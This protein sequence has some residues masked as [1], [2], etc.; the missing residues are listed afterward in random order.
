MRI[1][2]FIFKGN[3]FEN[4][5]LRIETCLFLLIIHIFDVVSS[6]IVQS[7]VMSYARISLTGL[8]L[9]SIY[10]LGMNNLIY[11]INLLKTRNALLRV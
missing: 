6:C 8:I 11:K 9:S 5:E 3:P 10:F 1:E 4:R 7:V 2:I